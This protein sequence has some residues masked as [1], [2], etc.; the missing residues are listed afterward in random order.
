MRGD[1]V[2]RGRFVHDRAARPLRHARNRRDRCI[3]HRSRPHRRSAVAGVR[4]TRRPDQRAPGDDVA[5]VRIGP[6]PGVL[7]VRLRNGRRDHGR[8]APARRHRRRSADHH[9]PPPPTTVPGER[10]DETLPTLPPSFFSSARCPTTSS[11]NSNRFPRTFNCRRSTSHRRRRLRSPGWP[12][13]CSSTTSCPKA[14]RRIGQRSTR[15]VAATTT[16]SPAVRHRSSSSNSTGGSNSAPSST[17]ST[18]P[19]GELR[20][21][22]H[23]RDRRR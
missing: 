16:P 6:D 8:T 14:G 20:D 4:S 5:R 15:V 1:V 22:V 3:V 23:R 21:A 19:P 2:E 9:D 11:R 13:R 10:P 7:R 12:L 18:R 17:R